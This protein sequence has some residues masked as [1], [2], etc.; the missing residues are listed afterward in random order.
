MTRHK[1]FG[2]QSYIANLHEISISTVALHL[3]VSIADRR[4]KLKNL[5]QLTAFSQ[6]STVLAGGLK[7]F[8]TEFSLIYKVHRENYF[9]KII[10]TIRP[11]QNTE[12]TISS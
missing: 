4:K 11:G 7:I 2:I 3:D 9:I 12:N 8:E 10:A 1:S 5:T 6:V